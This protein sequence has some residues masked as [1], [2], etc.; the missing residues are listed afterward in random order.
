[1]LVSKRAVHLGQTDETKIIEVTLIVRRKPDHDPIPD[2]ASYVNSPLRTRLSN[3]EFASRYGASDDDLGTL[4]AH[5]AG[6]G[7][8]VVPQHA[9]RR[10]I[11]LEGAVG[12]FNAV[13]GVQL[14][15]YKS[16][17]GIEFRAHNEIARVPDHL[18]G[19]IL[20]VAKLEDEPL[21]EPAV[22]LLAEPFS[23]SPWTGPPPIGPDPNVTVPLTPA[24][25]MSIYDSPSGLATG[26]TIG[27][28]V[29]PGWGVYS[30]TDLAST[31]AYYG[32]PTPSVT[33]ITIDS[34]SLG[35]NSEAQLGMSALATYGDGAALVRYLA[36]YPWEVCSRIVAPQPGDPVCNVLTLS[37]CSNE[38]IWEGQGYDTYFEDCALQGVS[39]LAA[40]GDWGNTD[41]AGNQAVNWPAVNPYVTGTGGTVL[42]ANS[43][44]VSSSNFVEWYWN[45]GNYGLVGGGGVSLY[46]PVPSYQSGV[47]FPATPGRGVPDIAGNASPNSGLTFYYLGTLQ[48]FGGTSYTS[49]LMAGIIARVN[50]A[51]GRNAGFLNPV[52]YALGLNNSFFRAMNVNGPTSSAFTASNPSD[53]EGTYTGYSLTY[54]TWNPL[55]GLGVVNGF[56][57]LAYLESHIT[58]AIVGATATS[59]AGTILFNPVAMTGAVATTGATSVSPAITLAATGA[60]ATSVA[61]T[62][63]SEITLAGASAI[64][65]AGRLLIVES[66]VFSGSSA[67]SSAGS[68]SMLLTPRLNGAISTSRAGSFS[69]TISFTLVGATATSAAGTIAPQT[70]NTVTLTGALATSAAHTVALSVT[71]VPGG[72]VATSQAGQLVLGPSLIGA[73]ATSS[74]HTVV[75]TLAITLVGVSASSA[76]GTLAFAI[77]FIVGAAAASSAGSPSTTGLTITL[78]GAAATSGATSP[79]SSNLVSPPGSSVTSAAGAIVPH[80]HRFMVGAVALSVPGSLSTGPEQFVT[81]IGASATSGAGQLLLAISPALP[82][83]T[84]AF[85]VA[86]IVTIAHDHSFRLQTASAYTAA[87]VLGLVGFS[88]TVQL[89][90]ASIQIIAGRILVQLFPPPIT[91]RP[92]PDRIAIAA[93]SRRTVLAYE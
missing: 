87:G 28:G 63:Q 55:V 36:T 8:T 22:S 10:Q 88:T 3:D 77:T 89:V 82:E 35:T 70:T 14:Q 92:N 42:G 60:T 33:T 19:I 29:F 93:R 47:S 71:I 11:Q 20:Q 23:S 72:A 84:S 79:A 65:A 24:T 39:I 18:N 58:V 50:H 56:N 4:T 69:P 66:F 12:Q 16:H 54:T 34:I 78:T 26:Q 21:A 32:V 73:A 1:M 85:T 57:L 80:V 51:L 59:G 37:Y 86:G 7:L 46:Y 49:P 25:V 6:L 2:F 31:C 5:F 68:L 40:A 91:V 38:S 45:E 17:G 9:A 52:L 90:G 30:G 53:P 76:A 43:G 48:T 64:S 83:G 62:I 61:G 13:F 15:D 27:I 75:G 67:T 74:A 44:T 41:G 81:P